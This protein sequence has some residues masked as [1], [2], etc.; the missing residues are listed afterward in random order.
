ME[1]AKVTLEIRIQGKTIKHTIPKSVLDTEN[2]QEKLEKIVQRV[3]SNESRVPEIAQLA[4]KGNV[5]IP[6]GKQGTPP[7]KR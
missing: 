6:P 7:G 1:G 4:W 3:A 5:D 2:S